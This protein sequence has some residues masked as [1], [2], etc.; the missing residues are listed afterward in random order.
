LF[1][2]GFSC[3]SISL[4]QS[5]PQTLIMPQKRRVPNGTLA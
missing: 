3:G 4:K 1:T 2:S 5:V